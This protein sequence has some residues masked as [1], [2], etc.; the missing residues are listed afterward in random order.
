[1]LPNANS[2]TEQLKTN[3]KF[4]ARFDETTQNILILLYGT[5]LIVGTTTNLTIISALFSKKVFLTSHLIKEEKHILVLSSDVF[6]RFYHVVDISLA[7][8]Q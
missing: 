3:K 5:I 8:S 6:A 4:I 7:P 2:D 1:M